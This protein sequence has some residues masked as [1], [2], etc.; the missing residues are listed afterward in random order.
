MH[1]TDFDC[2]SYLCSNLSVDYA[3]NRVGLTAIFTILLLTHA[4]YDLWFIEF[5]FLICTP[6]TI[7]WTIQ[8]L[9]KST[10]N[11]YISFCLKCTKNETRF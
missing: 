3:V 6:L 4:D 10:V 2:I 8:T 9:K 11:L 1:Q 5:E 7:H